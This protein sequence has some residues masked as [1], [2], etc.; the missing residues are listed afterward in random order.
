[1]IER[2]PTLETIAPAITKSRKLKLEQIKELKLPLIFQ[3]DQVIIEKSLNDWT[4]SAPLFIKLNQ[5]LETGEIGLV[6]YIIRSCI[7]N[8]PAMITYIF[9]NQSLVKMIRHLFRH[10]SQSQTS[11]RSYSINVK[12]YAS[13]LGYNP[14][15]IILDVKP[16]GAIPDPQR[17]LNHSDFLENYLA[18][19]QDSRP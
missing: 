15:E 7:N 2:K 5:I 3:D 18:E 19:V 12:K 13:W 6:D 10:C 1:M 9:E 4:L 17:V 8:C 11:C 16:V 14:D